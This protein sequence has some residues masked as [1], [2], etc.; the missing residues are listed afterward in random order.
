MRR[1]CRST[2]RCGISRTVIDAQWQSHRVPR[3]FPFRLHFAIVPRINLKIIMRARWFIRVAAC[4]LVR[5]RLFRKS[6]HVSSSNR[7]LHRPSCSCV[8]KFVYACETTR[9]SAVRARTPASRRRVAITRSAER[10][11]QVNTNVD[12]MT[13]NPTPANRRH[14]RSLITKCTVIRRKREKADGCRKM[15]IHVPRWETT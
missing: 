11:W 14:M 7:V 2:S 1:G 3:S 4:A 5:P 8:S 15:K 10:S 6:E 13:R 9:V 12:S